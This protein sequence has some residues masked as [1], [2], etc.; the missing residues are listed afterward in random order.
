MFAHVDGKPL[1]PNTVAYARRA[2][3]DRACVKAIRLHDARH[4]HA[5][6]M[7]KQGVHP[8]I[9]Q[10]RLGYTTIAMTLDKPRQKPSMG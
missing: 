5:S 9:V 6:L 10:E 4:R 3:A 7:L 2:A 1:R 8:E